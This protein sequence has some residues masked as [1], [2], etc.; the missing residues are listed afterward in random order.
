MD[1]S[2]TSS[3]RSD[4]EDLENTEETAQQWIYRHLIE[5]TNCE[6]TSARSLVDGDCSPLIQLLT[7]MTQTKSLFIT[8]TKPVV[9]DFSAISL[10]PLPV[11]TPEVP[12]AKK[13]TKKKGKLQALKKKKKKTK[14]SKIKVE[15]KKKEKVVPEIVEPPP[16]IVDAIVDMIFEWWT[17]IDLPHHEQF[18]FIIPKSRVP[19]IDARLDELYHVGFMKNRRLLKAALSCLDTVFYDKTTFAMKIDLLL[20]INEI[21][22]MKMSKELIFERFILENIARNFNLNGRI[23]NIDSD[24]RSITLILSQTIQTFCFQPDMGERTRLLIQLSFF[25]IE[26]LGSFPDIEITAAR[27]EKALCHISLLQFLYKEDISDW[28]RKTYLYL[29]D[30]FSTILAHEI[31][32][33]SNFMTNYSPENKVGPICASFKKVVQKLVSVSREVFETQEDWSATNKVS[34]SFYIVGILE[35]EID[36]IIEKVEEMNSE[37][38]DMSLDR[39]AMQ[40]TKVILT[41]LDAYLQEKCLES[42]VESGNLESLRSLAATIVKHNKRLERVVALY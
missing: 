16:P 22:D 25:D 40:A 26:Y 11:P 17:L 36:S 18:M 35:E 31:T 34:F 38:R 23:R 39:S 9:V 21:E 7:D 5:F 28:T 29:L 33:K 10:D 8:V 37:A 41:E 13:T 30:L 14:S 12:P 1:I 20:H 19:N 6:D 2:T 42:A 24:A 27:L 4:N 3:S 32:K 15:P